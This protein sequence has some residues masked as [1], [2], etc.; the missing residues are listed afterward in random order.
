[1]AAKT[2]AIQLPTAL[3]KGLNLRQSIVNRDFNSAQLCSNFIKQTNGQGTV[4]PPITE[5]FRKYKTNGS[6]EGFFPFTYDYFDTDTG[7][8]AQEL[9]LLDMSMDNAF[10]ARTVKLYKVTEAT[11]TISYSGTG[12]GVITLTPYLTNGTGANWSLSVTANGVSVLTSDAYKSAVSID[13]GDWGTFVA[14]IHALADFNC[15]P[16]SIVDNENTHT[17][18]DFV[19]KSITIASGGTYD[20]EYFTIEEIGSGLAAPR[21][22]TDADFILPSALCFSNNI[23]FAY[24]TYEQKYDGQDFYKSGLPI[25]EVTAVADSAG[26]VSFTIGTSYIY[27]TVFTRTDNKGNIIEG[28]DSDDTVSAAAHTMV[29]TRNMDVTVKSMRAADY[30]NH[31]IKGA[32]VN[33]AQAAVTTITVD[34]GHTME[35]GDRAYMYDSVNLGYQVNVTAVAATTIT[36]D[37]AVSVADNSVISNDIRIQIIRTKA[38]GTDFYNIVEIAN[39]WDAATV[40]YT[41]TT[42][43]SNALEPFTEQVR[44]HSEPPKCS[45]IGEHQGLKISAGDPDYPNRIS[46]ALPIDIEAYPLESNNTDIKGGGLGALTAFGTVS[47]DDI[48]VFKEFGHV[49]IKGT[50]DDLS[51]EIKDASNT[52]IGCTSFRSIAYVGENDSLVGVSRK[53]VFV[54]TNDS[55]SLSLGELIRPLFDQPQTRQVNGTDIPDSSY[56]SLLVNNTASGSI[57]RVLKRAVA[58]NDR[59]DSKYH[60]Y[61]PAEIGTPSEDKYPLATASK[62]LVFDYDAEVPYWTEYTAFDRLRFIATGNPK[63]YPLPTNGFCV[64]KDKVW[65]GTT[66]YDGSFGGLAFG[67]HNFGSYD[68]DRLDATFPVYLDV[69]YTPITRELNAAVALFKALFVNLYKF[70]EDR[71]TDP[72]ASGTGNPPLGSD[73]DFTIKCVKDYKNYYTTSGGTAS[74]TTVTNVDK[75]FKVAQGQTSV[76]TKVVTDKCRAFQIGLSNG[77]LTFGDTEQIKFDQ[78]ELVYCTPYDK[79][80]KDPKG[81]NV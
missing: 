11:L 44:K 68:D 56:Q 9:L 24:G 54:F 61:L 2:E 73:F 46:W 23:Y 33:G 13:T 53:G 80:Q 10:V 72:Q 66:D 8:N 50:L 81:V 25:G 15:S 59:I 71:I 79:K 12:N 37:S 40:T 43:D 62:Y 27:K 5:R 60:L 18:I 69:W 14:A 32:R 77:A 78:V 41:D 20:I 51:F 74:I 63:R 4:R 19:D 52:G 49:H 70:L 64:Y 38:D 48:V 39:V 31:A 67:L 42:G 34:A 75:T 16:T 26:G 29:A 65:F 55:P 36:V 58:I 30:P 22:F 35:V 3:F 76:P 45:F 1:M 17:H 28:E 47:D 21:V 7:A 6:C 57:E